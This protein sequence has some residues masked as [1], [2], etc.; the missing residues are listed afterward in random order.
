MVEVGVVD[1]P[2]SDQPWRLSPEEARQV[3]GGAMT[4]WLVGDDG[5]FL[6]ED[7]RSSN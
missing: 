7:D 5:R 2:P 3:A 6:Q 1:W 4:L